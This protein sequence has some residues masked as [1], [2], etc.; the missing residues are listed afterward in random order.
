M[1]TVRVR[2]IIGVVVV[3]AVAFGLWIASPDPAI[4]EAQLMCEGTGSV[5]EFPNMNLCAMDPRYKAGNCAC[6]R[7]RSELSRWYN[8]ALVPAIAAV[9]G[10]LLFRG[11]LK[12]RLLLLNGAVAVALISEMVRALIVDPAAAMTVMAYP[13]LLIVF[14][15]G[16]TAVFLLLHVLQ[17]RFT[18][19]ASAS[20]T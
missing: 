4:K 19:G 17:R 20:A 10:F 2:N 3:Y 6:L 9:L 5:A 16:I 8:L 15:I 1:T 7:P 13:V 18:R 14:C 11:S 12:A